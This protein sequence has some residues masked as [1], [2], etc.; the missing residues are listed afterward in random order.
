MIQIV[1]YPTVM[2]LSPLSNLQIWRAWCYRLCC[3]S[4]CIK[5]LGKWSKTF[6]WRNEYNKLL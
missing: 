5:S 3:L 4:N 1:V 6:H 2:V